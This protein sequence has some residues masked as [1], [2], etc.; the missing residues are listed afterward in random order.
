LSPLRSDGSPG[1]QA[2]TRSGRAIA[3]QRQK[4]LKGK[5]GKQ[6]YAAKRLNQTGV[7][8][9]PLEKYLTTTEEELLKLSKWMVKKRVADDDDDDDDNDE[10]EPVKP[11]LAVKS[12]VK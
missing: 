5:A 8:R 12:Q 2:G 6:L 9:Q 1:G 3:Q 11:D 4:T 7:K 10:G